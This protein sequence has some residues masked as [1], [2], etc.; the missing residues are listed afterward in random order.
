[1]FTSLSSSSSSPA[2]HPPPLVVA[3]LLDIAAACWLLMNEVSGAAVRHPTSGARVLNDRTAYMKHAQKAGMCQT[4]NDSENTNRAL[5]VPGDNVLSSFEDCV[6]KNEFGELLHDTSRKIFCNGKAIHIMADAMNHK[7]SKAFVDQAINMHGDDFTTK[8]DDWLSTTQESD[9]TVNHFIGGMGANFNFT[10]AG[11]ELHDYDNVRFPTTPKFV[12]RIRPQARLLRAWSKIVH[13]YW[14]I[15]DRTMDQMIGSYLIPGPGSDKN[16]E[17]EEYSTSLIRLDH[18]FVIAGGRFREQYYW[19][20]FFIMEGLLAANVT[21]LARTTLLNFMDQIKAYGFIPNGGRKYYLNRSQPPVFIHMLH[22]YMHATNDTQILHEALPLAERELR[23]WYSN[24]TVD[25]SHNGEVHKV[26]RYYVTATGPRPES[27][28]EDWRSVWCHSAEA[29]TKEHE[30]ERYSEFASG[31]ETGW[32]YSTRW[33]SNPFKQKGRELSLQMNDL[34]VR[35]TIPVDLNS[36]LYRCHKLMAHM[37]ETARLNESPAAQAYIDRHNNLADKLQRA[38]LALHWDSESSTFFDFVLKEKESGKIRTG[39][40]NRFWSG[41][42]LVPYWAEIWPESLHNCNSNETQ[43][44]EESR[45][46]TMAA[47]SGIRDILNRYPGPLPATLVNSG[48]QWDF[49][50]SWPPLQYFAIKALQNID[51]ACVDKT[52]VTVFEHTPTPQHYLGELDESS[53]PKKVEA[54]SKIN[55]TTSPSWRDVLV[56]TVVMRYMNAAYCTWNKEGQLPSDR[57]EIVLRDDAHLDKTLSS[58]P[59]SMFEKL[60]AMSATEAGGGGEYEVQTGFGWTNG[61]AI[62]IAQN[63]GAILDNPD[64]SNHIAHLKKSDPVSDANEELLFQ[65]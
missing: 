9:F 46:A 32:D 47:F 53:L 4:F 3:M 31:A 28:A 50:N 61:V 60:S 25:V 56:K 54:T 43:L 12:S 36:I 20:S 52:N 40:I 15:L 11:H 1:M 23:W 64:C 48:Q 57:V 34:R 21:Y 2:Y 18:P 14:N 42:S 45:N 51:N 63:F 29:P 55:Y 7:D 35:S 13:H 38:I 65:Y 30:Q 27:Y 26:F 49:P 10:A 41:A 39:A 44:R 62:W 16:D 6:A 17:R 59:G 19:D 8:I 5:V 22:A 37:Y 58:H 24:R 33:M